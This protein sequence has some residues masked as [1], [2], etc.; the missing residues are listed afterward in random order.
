VTLEAIY[1]NLALAAGLISE[2]RGALDGTVRADTAFALGEALGILA[3][4]KALVGRDIDERPKM[5]VKGAA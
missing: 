1:E 4:A 2:V 3:K 5:R